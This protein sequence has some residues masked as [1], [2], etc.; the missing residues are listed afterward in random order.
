[1]RNQGRPGSSIQLLSV[2][3]VCLMILAS[4]PEIDAQE[5]APSTQE[6]TWVKTWFAIPTVSYNSDNGLS[7]GAVGGIALGAGPKV[8][9]DHTLFLQGKMS[10]EGYQ[11]HRFEYALSGFGPQQVLSVS[12]GMKFRS[13]KRARYFGIGNVLARDRKL[14]AA[15]EADDARG[16]Y[17]RFS[18]KSPM[19]KAVVDA[20]VG[21]G[22]SFFFGFSPR[23]NE[24][25]PYEGS[26]LLED[27]APALRGGWTL[28]AL[29]GL[30]FDSR[31]KNT[32]S[33]V[34]LE[35]SAR[36]TVP[37][38]SDLRAGDFGG[39]HGNIQGF[40]SMTPSV[41]LAGR[42]MVDWLT[43]DIPFYE[44]NEWGGRQDVSG[45][46]GAE[47]LRGVPLG[48]WRGPGKAVMNIEARF[49]IGEIEPEGV[50]L[51]F[52]AVPFTDVGMVFDVAAEEATVPGLT[53]F[54]PT[55][56]LGLRMIYDHMFVARLDFG[57]GIDVVHEED[58][59]ISTEPF[60]GVYFVA[61]QLF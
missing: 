42:V 2:I 49:R 52:E 14:E 10:L 12:L 45:F 30:V 43:G 37:L 11:S 44:M 22:L 16:N 3:P 18:Q 8:A 21:S 56:G 58:G 46:G 32:L 26:L 36:H 50:H 17:Y 53:P 23:W 15:V 59:S 39:L 35:L 13:W 31:A 47:S 41:L 61:G 20:D 29:T 24:I 28:E 33:G 5:K 19:I 6:N 25:E 34:R 40:W 57:V 38:P 51:A 54:H 4:S 9:S 48:R 60:S 1:M 27:G 55:A 7:F